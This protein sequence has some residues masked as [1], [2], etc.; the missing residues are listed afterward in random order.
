MSQVRWWQ[1]SES[2]FY[3]MQPFAFAISKQKILSKMEKLPVLV[4][5]PKRSQTTNHES[6]NS[7]LTLSPPPS[8]AQPDIHLA[9]LAIYKH[10]VAINQSLPL[11]GYPV[12]IHGST[13]S[14]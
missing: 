4:S 11:K 6:H 8:P 9:W 5:M 2:C 13:G 10:P 14:P 1:L 7:E 12:S 3:C